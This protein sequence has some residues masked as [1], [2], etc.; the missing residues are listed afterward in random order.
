MSGVATIDIEAIRADERAQPR[1]MFDTELVSQYAEAMA[2]GDSFPPVTLFHDGADYFLADGFHRYHAAKSLGLVELAADVRE[3][4]LRDAILFSCSANANHGWRRTNDDKRRAVLRLLN[5][6]EWKLWSDREIGRRCGVDGKTVAAL[7]PKPSAEFPQ[8]E[9]TVQRGDAVYTQSTA[10]IGS[11]PAND[12]PIFDS[13]PSGENWR[14]QAAPEAVD[15]FA[16]LNRE[17]WASDIW[18][19]IRLHKPMPEA[20]EAAER[21]PSLTIHTLSPAELRRVATWFA[22]FADGIE[23]RKEVSNV[24]A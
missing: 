23:A 11:R 21:F 24:A 8:I 5:D 19:I 2:S 6:P 18:E 12:T 4:G 14:D 7:R 15:N 16:A 3:G 1:A 13:T 10:N 17:R 9:R 20:E 22:V